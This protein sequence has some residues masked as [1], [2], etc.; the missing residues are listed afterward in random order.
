MIKK[1]DF[2]ILCDK[3]ANCNEKCKSNPI[4]C[5][6][7][8]INEYAEGDKDKLLKLKAEGDIIEYKD[9]LEALFNRLACLFAG[10]SLILTILKSPIMIISALI[11]IVFCLLLMLKGMD[12]FGNVK[13]Y[14]KYILVVID[15][16]LK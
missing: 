4:V 15:D 12:A 1:N 9:F 8:Y 14:Q 6:R 2:E 10:V 3:L 5:A 11:V 13:K 7:H 16:E